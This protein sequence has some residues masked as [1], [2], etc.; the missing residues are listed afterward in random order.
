MTK[1]QPIPQPTWANKT[2]QEPHNSTEHKT[3]E[4]EAKTRIIGQTV[5]LDEETWKALAHLAVDEGKSQ[6]D[7]LLEGVGLVLAKYGGR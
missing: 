1:R 2:N 3:A 6:H 5:R 4:K 7:L